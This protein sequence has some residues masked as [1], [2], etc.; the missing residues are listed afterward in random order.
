[1]NVWELLEHRWPFDDE[2]GEIPGLNHRFGM[3]S[4]VG[5][6]PSLRPVF[7]VGNL[8]SAADVLLVGLKPGLNSDASPA[9]RAEQQAISGDLATYRASRT[10][11]FVSPAFNRRHYWPTAKAV[12]TILGEAFPYDPGVYLSQHAIQVELLPF[13]QPRAVL[14]D[15]DFMRARSDSKGGV[16]AGEVLDTLLASRPWRAVIIRYAQAFRL[17]T[18]LY[19]CRKRLNRTELVRDGRTIPVFNLAGRYVADSDVL[20]LTSGPGATARPKRLT[21]ATLASEGIDTTFQQLRRHILALGEDVTPLPQRANRSFVFRRKR[22]FVTLIP[23]NSSVQIDVYTSSGWREGVRVWP[24]IGV[25]AAS[26]L[27]DAAYDLAGS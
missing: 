19:D 22:N 17:F 9:F 21:D 26:A 12:A 15:S 1:M 16:L 8:D 10:D 27:I 7:F 4:A 13:F 14:S 6:S 25:D 5:F 18:G 20:A 24:G 11:Y 23:R 3:S 2:L